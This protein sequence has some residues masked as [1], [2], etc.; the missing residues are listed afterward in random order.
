V[1]Q[2][3]LIFGDQFPMTLPPNFN[4]F[5]WDSNPSPTN[6]LLALNICI[7]GALSARE[8]RQFNL[9]DE[10]YS[11]AR[12]YASLFFDEDNHSAAG[13]Y[14]WL[15][16]YSYSSGDLQKAACYSALSR[17]MAEETGDLG[18]WAY[19]H[20]TILEGHLSTDEQFRLHRIH[21]ARTIPTTRMQ[22]QM[23]LYEAYH[24]ALSL[25]PTTGEVLGEKVQQIRELCHLVHWLLEHESDPSDPPP[26]VFMLY[27]G[28]HILLLLDMFM[29]W[30]RGKYAKAHEMWN[31]FLRHANRSDFGGHHIFMPFT[32][33]LLVHIAQW[34]HI[35]LGGRE[36]LPLILQ[37]AVERYPLAQRLLAP[38]DPVGSPTPAAICQPER[39][40]ETFAGGINM[41]VPAKQ[42]LILG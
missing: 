18:S 19:C 21:E 2:Y 32:V 13:P 27:F 41:P 39:H 35:P 6:A 40:T 12:N 14:Y 8:M 16:L 17:R 38:Y 4:E 28:E 42:R 23:H 24:Q 3:Q 33:A 36:S 22:I 20:A 1:Q 9:A 29:A 5:L 11:K 25:R 7:A 30:L 26:R 31:T 15:G 37:Q 10:L 34:M